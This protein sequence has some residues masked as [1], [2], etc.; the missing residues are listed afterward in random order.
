ME[1]LAA[2]TIILDEF[3]VDNMLQLRVLQTS[4]FSFQFFC[5]SATGGSSGSAGGSS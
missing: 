3:D 1:D 4:S 2:L 5:S